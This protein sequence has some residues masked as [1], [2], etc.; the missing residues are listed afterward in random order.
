MEGSKTSFRLQT[1]LDAELL[2]R[3][4]IVAANQA[5]GLNDVVRAAL[6]AYVKDEEA[7]Q[8]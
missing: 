4:R 7:K 8:R 1:P 2:R 6:E 5:I 3:A